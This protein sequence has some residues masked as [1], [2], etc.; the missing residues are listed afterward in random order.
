MAIDE[1]PEDNASWVSKLMVFWINPLIAIAVYAIAYF[2]RD[3]YHR[4]EDD[5]LHF[6]RIQWSVYRLIS[7]D[8]KLQEKI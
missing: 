4:A 3:H 5:P 2:D 6:I 8:V 7:D 1:H